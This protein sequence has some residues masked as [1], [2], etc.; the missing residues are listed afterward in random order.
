MASS[1]R[2]PRGWC[3]GLRVAIG[4]GVDNLDD[5]YDHCT[6][7]GCTITCEPMDEA[8]GDRV[9]E[10]IDPFGHQLEMSHPALRWLRTNSGPAAMRGIGQPLTRSVS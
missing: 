6:R 1:R 4:L 5:A 8:L 7:N 3:R 9:C 10:C 2:L